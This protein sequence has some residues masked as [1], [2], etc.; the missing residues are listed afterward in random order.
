MLTRNVCLLMQHDFST[1]C[2]EFND[3]NWMIF[4]PYILLHLCFYGNILA[5]Q[6]NVHLGLR[7]LIFALKF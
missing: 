4:C 6:N 2:N 7:D 5:A 1:V 3:T